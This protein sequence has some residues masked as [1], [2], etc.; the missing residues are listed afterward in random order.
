MK[1]RF[2]E[3]RAAERDSIKSAGEP[4]VYRQA[5]VLLSEQLRGDA[6]EDD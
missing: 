6:G 2:A 4:V 1:H 3:E 5:Q